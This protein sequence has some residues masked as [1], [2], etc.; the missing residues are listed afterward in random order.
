[1]PVGMELAPRLDDGSYDPKGLV[2]ASAK[3]DLVMRMLPRLRDGG[4]RVLI[5]SNLVI[6]LN[7]VEIALKNAG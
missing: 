2:A 1:M 4:H 7:L 5:F 6:L 3:L